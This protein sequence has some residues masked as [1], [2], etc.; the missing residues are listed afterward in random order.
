[1]SFKDKLL[2]LHINGI[3]DSTIKT[4]GNVMPNNMPIF[5]GNTPWHKEDCNVASMIDE[6]RIYDRVISDDWL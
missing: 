2:K 3:L 5:I 4:V 1:M 6:F